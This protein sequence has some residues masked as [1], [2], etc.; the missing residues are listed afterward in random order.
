MQGDETEQIYWWRG[1]EDDV[2]SAGTDAGRRRGEVEGHSQIKSWEETRVG[3]FHYRT[4][5]L[6]ALPDSLHLREV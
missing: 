2:S 6:L 4:D 3:G 1:W 5:V